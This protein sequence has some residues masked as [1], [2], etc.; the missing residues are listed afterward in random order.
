MVVGNV[1]DLSR[2]NEIDRP[3]SKSTCFVSLLNRGCM[4][5]TRYEAF[6]TEI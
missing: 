2:W 4:S 1:W 6:T 5:F 3:E